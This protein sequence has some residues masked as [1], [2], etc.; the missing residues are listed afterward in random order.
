[1]CTACE[2]SFGRRRF[3]RRALVGGGLVAVVGSVGELFDAPSA[4]A[5]P[6]PSSSLPPP[7]EDAAMG[8]DGVIGTTDASATAQA[9]DGSPFSAVDGLVQVTNAISVAAPPIVRRAQW[10]ADES[11]RSN[12]RSYAPIRKFVVHHTASANHPSNPAAVIREMYGYHIQR[13]YTDLGYNFV[14]DHNGVIYE[15]RYSRPYGNGEQVTG[16]D[17]NGWGI[18]GGHAAAMNGATCGIVL[19]G[20]FTASDP[21][22]AAVASLV[23]LLSWK[24]ARHRIDAINSDPYITRFGARVTTPNIAGHRQIGDTS[25]PGRLANLLPAIRQ[26]VA[27]NAGAWPAITI[28]ITKV[29]RYEFGAQPTLPAATAATAVAVGAGAGAGSSATP[30]ATAS[31]GPL[32]PVPMAIGTTGEAVKVVQRALR[33]AGTRV[34]VD[35]AFGN[36]TRKA[37]VSFQTAKGLSRSG[38]ADLATVSA[39][40]LVD[41]TKSNILVVPLRAG[42]KGN[43]VRRVQ[44]ALVNQSLRVAVDGDFGLQTRFAV[45]QFQKKKGLRASGDVDLATAGA[46]GVVAATAPATA[47]ATAS[48]LTSGSSGSSGSASGGP[49]SDSSVISLPVRIGMRGDDVRAV[50]RALRRSGYALTVDGN[51]GPVTRAVVTRFQT[52]KGLSP[53]GDVYSR[54]AAALGLT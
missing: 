35:G 8:E 29:T 13:G 47:T 9:A 10:G 21:T 1:M 38:Q 34:G 37:L 12:Q 51:F 49:G 39:L 17:T 33:Q 18:V 22:D 25:C 16:E 6:V 53:T 4:A 40:G 32:L 50:Q 28:D 46:L 20:D 30:A 5:S 45:H 14:I 43:A 54:T 44:G 27:A 24:A 15:G 2:P 48:A 23:W 31:A 41:S 26:Q 11:L 52:A 3:I 19:M 36:Q 42:A 7:F